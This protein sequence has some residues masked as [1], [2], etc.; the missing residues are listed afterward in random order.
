MRRLEGVNG[1]GAAVGLSQL[2]P[3]DG[4]RAIGGRRRTVDGTDGDRREQAA[5]GS[6]VRAGRTGK[7]VGQELMTSFQASQIRRAKS[8]RATRSW[9][10][11]WIAGGVKP[12]PRRNTDLLP[13]L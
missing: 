7:T 8:S 1:R 4:G 5:G 10:G 6:E 3:G 12:P 2:R 9:I 13:T 11:S